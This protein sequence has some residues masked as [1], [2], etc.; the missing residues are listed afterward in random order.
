MSW[1]FTPY[2]LP[3]ILSGVVLAALAASVWRRRNA[4]PGAAPFALMALAGAEYALGY[5]VELMAPDLPRKIL[6]AKVEYLGLVSLAPLF[7][8]FAVQYAGLGRYLSKRLRGGLVVTSALVFLLAASNELHRLIWVE[9]NLR[10][11]GSA[12]VLAPV[13]GPAF[14]IFTIYSYILLFAGGGLLV[15]VALRGGWLYRRQSL[16]LLGGLLLPIVAN[17]SYG[18]GLWP[19]PYLNPTP[20]VFS[21]SVALF[22]LAILRFRLL[23]LV[24][25]ARQTLVEQMRDGML[26]VDGLGRVTDLNPAMEGLIGRRAAEAIGRP[27][28]EV[29]RGLPELV[30]YLRENGTVEAEVSV[31]E[32]S[33]R[34]VYALSVTPL[35]GQPAWLPGRLIVVRD[36]TRAKSLEAQYLQ[37]QKMELIGHLARGVAHDFNNALTAIRGYASL[38]ADLLPA[39]SPAREHLERLLAN[40]ERAGRLSQQLLAFSRRQPAS[41]RELDMN[42]LLDGLRDLLPYTLATQVSLEI[43]PAPGLWRVSADPN[44]MEQVLLNLL[45]NAVDAVSEGGRVTVSTAN[46]VVSDEDARSDGVGLPGEYVVLSVSDTGV[47]MTEEVRAHLFEPFFTTKQ[48]GKGS[49]LGLA[50]VYSIV[51]QHGGSITVDSEAGRGTTFRVYLPRLKEPVPPAGGAGH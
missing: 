19:M 14:W 27:V 11:A 48:P 13:R 18:L 45:L 24:P 30:A 33:A 37:A 50:T 35:S 2:V 47:G 44:Q 51:G 1:T 34:R 29:L 43:D 6:C 8:V 25:V 28:E 5:A 23:D 31:G 38:A 12:V 32:G 41:P 26:V 22:A 3:L 36:I 39:A 15:S 4:A 20:V 46:V 42:D 16:A 9:T 21:V 40:V 49:G 17:V 10:T 7:F